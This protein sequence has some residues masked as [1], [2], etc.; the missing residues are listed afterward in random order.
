MDPVA[1]RTPSRQDPAR[2]CLPVLRRGRVLTRGS[3]L[4]GGLSSAVIGYRSSVHDE[5]RS[6]CAGSGVVPGDAVTTMT[7]ELITPIAV[8]EGPRFAIR[9]GGRTVGAAGSCRGGGLPRPQRI[10]AN[11]SNACRGVTAGSLLLAE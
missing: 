2:G 7:V 9:A 4:G 3:P 8:D 10:T 6:G 1:R 5:T 11:P